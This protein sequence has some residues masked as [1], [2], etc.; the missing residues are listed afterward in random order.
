LQLSKIYLQT[1]QRSTITWHH[2]E[3]HLRQTE[4]G[5]FHLSMHGTYLSC[6]ACGVLDQC[7]VYVNVC[8]LQTDSCSCVPCTLCDVAW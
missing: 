8:L 7:T 2:R 5:V 3:H 6:W 1:L 4:V